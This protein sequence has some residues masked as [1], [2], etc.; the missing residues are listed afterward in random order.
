ML[1]I[2]I[3]SV[4]V[5]LIALRAIDALREQGHDPQSREPAL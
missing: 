4:G 2:I 1:P 3:G 5:G